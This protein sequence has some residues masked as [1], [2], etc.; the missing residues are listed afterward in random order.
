M[1]DPDELINDSEVETMR[2]MRCSDFGSAKDL[3]K[4]VNVKKTG[5]T[6]QLFDSM[7]DRNK[8]PQDS[9][10]VVPDHTDMNSESSDIRKRNTNWRRRGKNTPS[11]SIKE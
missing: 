1:V 3:M 4:L 8:M 11:S 9:N 7:R 10:I 2:Y 6:S 5:N